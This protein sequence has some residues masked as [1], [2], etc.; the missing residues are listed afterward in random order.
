MCKECR[1]IYNKDYREKHKAEMASYRI[2]YR[3]EHRED[4]LLKGK[5]YRDGHK[6]ETKAWRQGCNRTEYCRKYNS[7][8]RD[9][10][11]AN[12]RKWRGSHKQ[13]IYEYGKMYRKTHNVSINIL[14]QSR[15]ARKSKLSH[16]LTIEQW[17]RVQTHFNHRCAYCGEEKPLT[18][19]HY[20]PLSLGGEYSISNIICACS[21]CNSSKG[22]KLFSEWYP[23]QKYYSKRRESKVLNYLKYKNNVQQLAFI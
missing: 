20:Y 17:N 1:V 22:A 16:T 23:K 10:L 6:E 19:D 21:R 3:E 18:Q 13:E 14:T 4:I 2:R 11:N 8:H 12:T 9:S 5:I 15:K 7:E